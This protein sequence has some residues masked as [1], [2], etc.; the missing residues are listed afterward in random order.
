MW[1]RG[2]RRPFRLRFPQAS[3]S[4]GESVR[5]QHSRL[6]VLGHQ[7]KAWIWTSKFQIKPP[8]NREKD[9]KCAT[10]H[11]GTKKSKRRNSGFLGPGMKEIDRKSVGMNKVI[12]FKLP[13]K[14]LN[15]YFSGSNP[16]TTNL[17]SCCGCV[18][19]AQ[20]NLHSKLVI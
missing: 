17:S 6:K 15:N 19:S 11:T 13:L 7:V 5:H 9:E 3:P 2:N 4:T 18:D 1:T 8:T 12:D 20:L 16:T 14:K 10:R